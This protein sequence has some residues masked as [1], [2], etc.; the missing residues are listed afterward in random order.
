MSNTV[1]DITDQ[2]RASSFEHVRAVIEP[3]DVLVLLAYLE[4]RGFISK[5]ARE[6]LETDNKVYEDFLKSRKLT[7]EKSH[8][9]TADEQAALMADYNDYLAS[10]EGQKAVEAERV[11]AEKKAEEEAKAETPEEESDLSSMTKDELIA[12]ADVRGIKVNKANTKAEII[13]EIEGA[14]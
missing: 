14:K 5:E 9:L 1:H 8:E 10:P 2:L 6:A 12:F 13:E 11:A 7:V 3:D 4:D